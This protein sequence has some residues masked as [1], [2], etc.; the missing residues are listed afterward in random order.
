MLTRIILAS[1][2]FLIATPALAGGCG[3]GAHAQ[4]PQE[5][6]VKYFA[7]MDANG[8]EVVTKDEF[9]ASPFSK[10]LK[11]FDVLQPNEDGVVEKKAFI[12]AFVKTHSKPATEA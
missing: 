9:A 2:L 12:E 7:Q 3:T 10:I 8:D 11:S 1:A 4:N 6:A 5:I